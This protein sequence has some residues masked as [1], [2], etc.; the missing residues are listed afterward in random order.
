M[1]IDNIRK[2]KAH[3]GELKIK[4]W[5]TINKVSP[6]T[7]EK[8]EQQAELIKL[9]KEF[10]KQLWAIR[11]HK[12]V[13]C[14]CNIGKQFKLWNWHHLLNKVDYWQ[15]RHN[16]RNVILVCLECHS[17]AETNLDFAPKIKELELQ[18]EKELLNQ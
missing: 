3:A 2:L 12:C 8:L 1:G 5:G 17:K 7:A 9:D 4:K 14:G 10:Y 18:A 16:P 15:F 11:P 13:N 6:K